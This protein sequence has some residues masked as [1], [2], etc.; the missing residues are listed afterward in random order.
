[1]QETALRILSSLATDANFAANAEKGGIFGALHPLVSREP[2][3]LAALLALVSSYPAARSALTRAGLLP[4]LVQ[5]L[6]NQVRNWRTLIC[7]SRINLFYKDE[8]VRE[9]AMEV[10]ASAA[11]DEGN[12][13]LLLDMLQPVFSPLLE[14]KRPQT[15]FTALCTLSSVAVSSANREKLRG[16]PLLSVLVNILT[17]D[18]SAVLLPALEAVDSL[19]LDGTLSR[20]RAYYC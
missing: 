5:Q 7:L 8:A 18:H 6:S 17:P 12:R 16:S 20:L 1:M 11:F 2:R 15:Q 19:C 13:L 3:S 10:I 9:T 14:S 4:L